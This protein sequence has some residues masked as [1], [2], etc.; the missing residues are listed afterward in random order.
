MKFEIGAMS[1]GDMLDRGLKLLWARFG[2]FY[3]ITLIVLIPVLI[4]RLLTPELL[5]PD[6]PQPKGPMTEE[7][8][9]QLLQ[10]MMIWFGQALAL[11]LLEVVLTLLATGATLHVTAGEYVDR[12][13]GMR[14]AFGHV[15]RRLGPL[16]GSSILAWLV[17]GLGFFLC[18]VPMFIFLTWYVFVAQVVVLEGL[19]GTG[20]LARSKELSDGFRW[21]IF[22]MFVL[23]WL[24]EVGMGMLAQLVTYVLPPVEAVPGPGG[25]IQ[26]VN[27]QNY[28]I[29]I[30]IAYLVGVVAHSYA[31]VCWTLFYFD[32]RIRKEGFDLELMARRGLAGPALPGE[33][34]VEVVDEE[35]PADNRDP[36]SDNP[37]PPLT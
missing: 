30:A 3:M 7:Q 29:F 26:V 35:P 6:I 9:A 4:I 12:H 34:P 27:T 17:I 8:A 24:I 11:T 5:F 21:R 18:F 20:A 15:F 32:L 28:V 22:G 37:N 16:L 10:T 33:I 25:I 19:S 36:W 1:V 23:L 2:T 13:V 14:E 31:I